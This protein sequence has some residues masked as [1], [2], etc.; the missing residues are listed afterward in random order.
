MVDFEGKE[1]DVTG[2]VMDEGGGIESDERRV[3]MVDMVVDAEDSL[4]R[5]V[6]TSISSMIVRFR[7]LDMIGGF[8]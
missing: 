8:D 5:V 4:D 6:R 1:G 7:F 3:D 2:G